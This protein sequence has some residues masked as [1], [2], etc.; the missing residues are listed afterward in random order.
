MMFLKENNEWHLYRCGQNLNQPQTK[1]FYDFCKG[2][3]CN[4]CFL[5]KSQFREVIYLKL[6]T[7]KSGKVIYLKEEELWEH[8]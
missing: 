5:K 4:F 8:Y 6:A 2:R 3:D 1:A 7:M